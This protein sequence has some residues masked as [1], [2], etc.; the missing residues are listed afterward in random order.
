MKDKQIYQL[1]LIINLLQWQTAA[2]L[3]RKSSSNDNIGD[4]ARFQV[5]K[6]ITTN[7]GYLFS[8]FG[9]QQV[10]FIR[11]RKSILFLEEIHTM[12]TNI[13]IYCLFANS[14]NYCLD[15]VDS[16]NH[17]SLAKMF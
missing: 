10:N 12:K 6:I 9:E 13:I 2:V 3:V 5:R 11:N 17:F 16:K 14:V 7:E 15:L 4:P 8:N 1:L